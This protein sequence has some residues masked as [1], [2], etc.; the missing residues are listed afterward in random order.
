MIRVYLDTTAERGYVIGWMRREKLLDYRVQFKHMPQKNKSEKALYLAKK[1]TEVDPI[2][3]I[4][5]LFSV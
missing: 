4:S 1:L 5:D 3:R 2:D